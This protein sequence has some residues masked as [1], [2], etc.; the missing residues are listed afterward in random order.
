VGQADAWAWL[1]LCYSA[2]AFQHKTF[3]MNL[4]TLDS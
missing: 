4:I 2:F 3:K 1:T